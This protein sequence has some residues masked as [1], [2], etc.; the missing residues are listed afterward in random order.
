MKRRYYTVI[1]FY[2]DNEQ[3]W[4]GYAVGVTALEA[5]IKAI[6]N[7]SKLDGQDEDDD[8]ITVVEVVAGKRQGRLG[9]DMCLNINGLRRL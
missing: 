2:R 6:Q 4:M 3:P 9:N 7:Q 5:A 1:G 8:R